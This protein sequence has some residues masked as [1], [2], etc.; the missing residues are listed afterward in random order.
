[1]VVL[2]SFVFN[3][4]KN[5]LETLMREYQVICMR[6]LWEVGDDGANSGKAWVHVSKVLMEQGKTISRASIIFFLNDMVE[7]R[8]LK[9]IEKSGKGG[10]HRVYFPIHDENGFKEYVI[11]KLLTKLAE[12]W[13]DE[14]EKVISAF[15]KE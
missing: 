13:P 10:Y 7:R 4:E 8:V 2:V 14:A 6:Y 15:K 12:E 1:M 9:F 3:T 11:K 5:G